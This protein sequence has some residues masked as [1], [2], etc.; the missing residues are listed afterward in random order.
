MIDTV[1]AYTAEPR[2]PACGDTGL[3]HREPTFGK[4]ECSACRAWVDEGPA[5]YVLVPRAQDGGAP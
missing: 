1:P 2:C 5:G 3:R 4:L